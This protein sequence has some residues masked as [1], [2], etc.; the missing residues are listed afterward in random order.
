MSEYS[1]PSALAAASVEELASLIY[2][3]G[4]RWR[5]PLLKQLGAA[6]AALGGTPPDTLAELVA[7]PGVGPYAA[8]AYLSFHCNKRAVLIDANVVR[9][10]CRMVGKPMDGETRRKAWLIE[11]ADRLTPARNARDYNYAILDFSMQ[12][13]AAKPLCAQCPLGPKLC[14]TGRKNLDVIQS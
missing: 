14:V 3:L 10:L 7:L 5:A 1:T 11:I 4:L 12:I 13:C 6:L 9:W 8:A 2:P